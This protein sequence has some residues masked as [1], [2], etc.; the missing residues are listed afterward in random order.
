MLQQS[1][2]SKAH[3]GVMIASWCTRWH[4]ASSHLRDVPDKPSSFSH[5]YLTQ[6]DPQ[7]DRCTQMALK[8]LRL[9]QASL[10]QCSTFSGRQY[11]SA[12]IDRGWH[13]SFVSLKVPDP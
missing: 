7:D 1:S 10:Q 11:S 13:R 9:M 6:K 3:I 8:G 2:P 12:T 5:R 4:P